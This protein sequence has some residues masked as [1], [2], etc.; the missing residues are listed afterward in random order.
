MK[1]D[2]ETMEQKGKGKVKSLPS[3]SSCFLVLLTFLSLISSATTIFAQRASGTI[4]GRVVADDGQPIRH[5]TINIMG[6][7]GGVKRALAGRLAIVTDEDGDFQADGLDPIPYQIS[8]TAPGYVLAPNSHV[9]SLYE[10]RD[11]LYSYVGETVTIRMIRG[12]VITG[13]VTS[14]TGEPV[15]G[16]AVKA[17]RVRDETGRPT[18]DSAMNF[19]PERPT[20]DRGIYRI[21]GLAP[22]TY[23]ISASGGSQAFSIRPLPFS[24]RTATFHPS[25]TRDAA[26]EVKIAGGDEVSG[27]DIRYRG[28]R[29]FAISGQVTGAR[30]QA[31]VGSMRIETTVIW[32][33]NPSTG[34]VIATTYQLPV[35]DQKSYAF[36][37]IP[38]GEYEVVATREGLDSE[39]GMV[40]APRRVNVAGR[41]VAGIDL[42]LTA[43]ASIAGAVMIEK[44]DDNSRKCVSNRE[45][46]IGELAVKARRDESSEKS[47]LALPSL[48]DSS[49][50]GV[51]NESGGFII[52]NLRPGRHRIETQLPDENWYLKAM[53]MTP[54]TPAANPRNGLVVKAGDRITGLNLTVAFGAASLKGKVLTEKNTV[55]LR[56]HLLPADLGAKDDVL[57][58]SEALAE[59]DRT[60]RFS[61][62]APG[63][64][65]IVVRA[66]PETEQTGLLPRRVAWDAAERAKLRKEAEA[67]NVMI[68]LKFCQHVTEYA[69]RIGK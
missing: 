19:R 28:E 41:D 8:A 20:D 1:R 35:G 23:L 16:I 21:Y 22:G 48:S 29:G 24:G 53:T 37:G 67:T 66:E 57:R 50:V 43:N 4:T 10:S 14:P 44:P 26:V 11:A 64:Y 30:S 33:R 58:F 52:R 32:L 25:S 5:A 17:M 27:I 61:N 49:A 15:I 46:H 55:K 12:G 62:L 45:S 56:V 65:L 39:N 68:E 9:K 13:K 6:V 60:F 3:V 38:N 18:N 69:L 42:M 2:K 63:K 51:P 47:E 31:G 40:S 34:T 36:Y 54:T 59:N 7:G